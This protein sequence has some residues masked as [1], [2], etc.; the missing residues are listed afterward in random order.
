MTK[1]T[2]KVLFLHGKEGNPE[3]SKVL[4]LKSMGYEVFCPA[5]NTGKGDPDFGKYV[6]G[7]VE[8]AKRALR[9]FRPDVVVGSSF[10]GA[11]LLQL[12][13]EGVCRV[14]SI[15]MAGAGIL[16]GKAAKLPHDVA[17]TLIHGTEDGIIP[18]EH[19]ILLVKG[20]PN[21]NLVLL[22]DN[23]RLFRTLSETGILYREIQKFTEK[24]F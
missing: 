21:A 24:L 8:V 7:C 11:V 4:Y 18:Y 5:Y 6:P 2:T 17:V 10:G 15:L 23:H 9:D 3:G 14:P 20:H 12:L 19:S 1:N 16:Y 22:S 13:Q